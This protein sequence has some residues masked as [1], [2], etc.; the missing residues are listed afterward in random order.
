MITLTLE[1]LDVDWC[2]WCVNRLVSAYSQ[3]NVE[4]Y[5][6]SGGIQQTQN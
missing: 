6:H 3:R 1:T 4:I 2:R 5:C